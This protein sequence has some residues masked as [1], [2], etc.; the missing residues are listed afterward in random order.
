ME[1]QDTPVNTGISKWERC[2]SVKRAGEMVSAREV[3]HDPHDRPAAS[4][5][6]QP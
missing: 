2:I 3:S 5:T 6:L 1:V 4:R